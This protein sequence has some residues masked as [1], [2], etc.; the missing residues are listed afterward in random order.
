[1]HRI[2]LRQIIRDAEIAHAI[3]PI[4]RRRTD[5]IMAYQPRPASKRF[6][7]GLP[8]ER[9]NWLTS[10]FLIGTLLLTLSAVPLD[11]YHSALD[12]FQVALFCG[13]LWAFGFSMS[14]A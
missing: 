3:S 11:L 12:W 5:F 9:I 1:M 6:V 7:F 2:E 8:F 10:S 13:M 14:I 4:V